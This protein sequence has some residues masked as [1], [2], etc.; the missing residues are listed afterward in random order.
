[1]D[2]GTDHQV[3]LAPAG[4]RTRSLPPQRRIPTEDDW[5]AYKT[6]LFRLVEEGNTADELNSF[7][8]NEGLQTT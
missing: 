1:M 3:Y 7:M 4:A 5:E 6:I 2:H 8:R